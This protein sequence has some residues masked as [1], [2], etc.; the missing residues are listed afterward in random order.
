[1]EHSSGATA[2]G[3]NLFI[4]FFNP[5]PVLLNSRIRTYMWTQLSSLV[6]WHL[7]HTLHVLMLQYL[8]CALSV[9]LKG[10]KT[11]LCSPH[12]KATWGNCSCEVALHTYTY[13]YIQYCISRKP[14]CRW[15]W[16][17]TWLLCKS[18]KT[19]RTTLPPCG[20]QRVFYLLSER[21]HLFSWAG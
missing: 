4:L 13:I 3:F 19:Q 1:M 14:T 15:F 21:A 18:L 5:V 20:H 11:S 8:G 10:G 16:V 17:S 7:R 9:T 6:G 2:T 12:N